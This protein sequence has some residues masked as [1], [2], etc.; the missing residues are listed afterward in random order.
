MTSTIF[1]L[2]LVLFSVISFGILLFIIIQQ[3]K[4]SDLISQQNKMNE[5]QKEKNSEKESFDTGN[6][7]ADFNASID[8]LRKYSK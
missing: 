5:K 2:V 8:V 6:D 7:V 4:T 3:K 1:I